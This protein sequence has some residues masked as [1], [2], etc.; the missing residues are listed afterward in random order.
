VTYRIETCS[1]CHAPIIWALTSK[2]LRRIPIDPD[3]VPNGNILLGTNEDPERP[4][5]AVTLSVPQRFGKAELRVSHFV[6][7]PQAAAHR[8]R[9]PS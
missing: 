8:R 1:T 2:T 9:R 5:L 6:T 4:P 3:P 7:C